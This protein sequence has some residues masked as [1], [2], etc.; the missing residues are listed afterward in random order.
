[1]NI[2]GTLLSM[3]LFIAALVGCKNKSAENTDTQAIGDSNPSAISSGSYVPETG[4][5]AL[6]K[7]SKGDIKVGLEYKRAPMTV[8]N[9]VALAEGKMPNT[10]KPAGE[11]FYNGLTF[12]RVI[13]DFM[14][15]GG[16]P[17]ADGT[18]DAGY[19]FSDEFDPNLFHDGPGV[20]SMANSG[21]NTNSSQ[22]FITHVATPWL[23]NKHSIFGKVI[24]GMPVVNNIQQGDQ[25]LSIAIERISEEAKAFDAIKVFN[26]KGLELRKRQFASFDAYVAQNFPTA[27]K[28]NSNLYYIIEKEGNGKQA[29]K[30]TTVKVHYKG[31]LTDGRVF[32]SSLERGEPIEF[33]LGEGKV[34]AGWD[35]GI[36]LLKVGSKAKLIIPH[37]LAYGSQGAPPVIPSDANLIFEVELVS[38]K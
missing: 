3:S 5:V 32:D 25:I 28:T 18:G 9:F 29:K 2:Q 23:N 7:T 34:I 36:A 20:L 35:E 21:V 4:M 8:A 6:I 12:H 27:L 26:E 33:P 1:M 19:K 14:I 24:E 11:P 10:A 30:G 13:K 15:Q 16:D 38:V 31:M 17:K 37:Q 22:F